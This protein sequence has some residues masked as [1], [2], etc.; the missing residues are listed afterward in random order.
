MLYNPMLV[1]IDIINVFRLHLYC[2]YER[3]WT[4]QRRFT[5][6]TLREFGFG[7]SGMEEMINNEVF[8]FIPYIISVAN[9]N[10]NGTIKVQN[11]FNVSILNALW[12]IIA[13]SRY[14]YR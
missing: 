8:E 10:K 12:Q 4:E 7:K 3:T 1:V 14:D 11:L 5:L 9:E 2:S 6:R 13:G